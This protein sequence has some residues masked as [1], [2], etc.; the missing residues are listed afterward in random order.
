M[1]VLDEVTSQQARATADL[2][3]QSAAFADRFEQAE[4]PGR[5]E[6]GVEAVPL[7]MYVREI[8]AVDRLV[9]VHVDH[10]AVMAVGPVTVLPARRRSD[11]VLIVTGASSEVRHN[12]EV[13]F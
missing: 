12:S 11:T 2:E 7:V 4:D 3:H 5:A 13:D 6:F 10:H 1:P 8:P 9:V